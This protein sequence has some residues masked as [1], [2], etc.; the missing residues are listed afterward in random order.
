MADPPVYRQALVALGFTQEAATD[1]RDV[2]QV[3]SLPEIGLLTDKDV[4][5][6]CKIV[7]RPGGTNASGTVNPGNSV[8]LRAETNLKLAVYWYHHHVRTSRVPIIT[9]M[10]LVNVR[11]LAKLRD[12]ENEHSDPNVLPTVKGSDWPKILESLQEYFRGFIGLKGTPLS[13]VIRTAEEVPDAAKDPSFGQTN[14]VYLTR[15]EEMV[16][17]APMLDANKHPTDAFMVDRTTVWHKLRDLFR[18]TES[19]VHIKPA[20]RTSNGRLAWQRLWNHYLGPNNVDNMAN[21]S[22]RVIQ[23]SNY[24]GERK[25]WNF[26][27]YVSLHLEQHAILEGLVQ[28]GYSGIDARSKVRHLMDGIKTDSLNAVK[29]QI[30]AQASLRSDFDSCVTL[31][32]DFISQNKKGNKELNVSEVRV[33]PKSTGGGETKTSNDVPDRFYTPAE[34]SKLTKEQ[35][36]K[37]YEKRKA[38]GGGTGT[39]DPKRMKGNQSESKTVKQLTRRIAALEKV[40]DDNT[41]STDDDGKADGNRKHPALT[42]QPADLTKKKA[43]K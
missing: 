12:A 4:E 35:K 8:S 21:Q 1:I 20:Q 24:D 14:S 9:E 27:R 2:Q 25:R 7:R 30:M 17:R 22:E 18:D 42:R 41:D 43:N 32:K 38:R 36:S 37:L 33:K 11:A 40:N 5:N 31:Y 26:E 13:Y 23:Q 19:W 29:T 15:E 16:A 39:R 10:T 34:Y 3:N 6:L 28:Y